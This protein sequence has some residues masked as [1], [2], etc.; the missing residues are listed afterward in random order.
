MGA[1]QNR[2]PAAIALRNR[3]LFFLAHLMWVVEL[4]KKLV[5]VLDTIDAKI[6]TLDILITGPHARRLIR[7]VTAI[8]GQREVGLAAADTGSG[9]RGCRGG[10][11][12]CRA[13][14]EHI[15]IKRRNN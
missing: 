10:E 2:N 13:R 5:R 8:G 9:R 12:S 15:K 1:L 6:Q 7:R 4:L 3:F 11:R 14:A